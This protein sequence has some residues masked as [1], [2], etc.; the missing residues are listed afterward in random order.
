VVE[1]H[2]VL[3]NTH[4]EAISSIHIQ[5]LIDSQIEVENIHFEEEGSLNV[6]NEVFGHYIYA[7][8][9]PLQAGDSIKM[10]FKQIYTT[11]GFVERGSNKQIVENGTFFNVDHFPTIGYNPKYELRDN[12][13]RA[14]Y[15]LPPRPTRAKIDDS[16][17]LENARS[18]GGGYEINFEI[19]IGTDANQVALA[20]GK[21]LKTWS[22]QGRS[23]FHYKSAEPMINFYSI[24]SAE[25]E[26]MRDQW[27]PKHGDPVDLE[28]Y[29]HKG[30]DYNLDRMMSSMK[31]S[32]D[33]FDKNFNTYQYQQ[34]RIMEFPRYAGF[35][36][37]F[38]NTVPYSESI[39]FIMDIDEEEDA[40]MPFFVTAHE[41]AHQWWGMQVIAANVEGRYMI[42]ETLAQYAALMVMKKEF[43]GEKIE[44]ILAGERKRYLLGRANEAAY[45]TPLALV[46]GGKY[47]YYGK[48]LLNMYAF[49]DY[50]SEDSVNVALR[51]FIKDWNGF[52][53]ELQTD[54]YAT[55]EDLLT[56]FKEVT[57]D[58][59]QYIIADLFE[60][61]T[62]Y[63]NRTTEV[64]YEAISADQY[65][66]G[67][68]VEAIKLRTD[69][70]GVESSIPINDWIDIG[71]YAA[72]EDG[73]DQL[74]Y[75]EKH[76][77]KN[78]TTTLEIYV[79]QKPTK[80]GIDPKYKLIDRNSE[81]NV[82]V[83][84]PLQLF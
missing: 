28:I 48:G 3:E 10:A 66:V 25:Y 73:E 82:K 81:D 9:E 49:Q 34:M 32:F 30:H 11:S 72:G 13:D 33:Y 23:Y 4:D 39:G 69:S 59:L 76:Q 77:V 55:T 52:G 54:R 31:H 43:P 5:K 53:G 83:I 60:T 14:S 74:I 57:P 26:V 67:L 40:D 56:Y 63:E 21:L 79:D 1:G 61:I 24:V 38:P 17:Q 27:M 50:V 37:S 75:L 16:I 44:K 42:L 45:E 35:A 7:L 58:S 70:L 22:D 64:S 29:Y 20:P 12:I 84:E 80:A 15:N 46:D 18:S 62:L 78:Q 68:T 47:I 36:Q 71:V 19:V 51:R 41:L 8:N 65:R 6:D 2:Y